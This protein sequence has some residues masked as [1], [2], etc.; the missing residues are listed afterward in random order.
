MGVAIGDCVLDLYQCSLQKLLPEICQAPV[1]N[2]LL[3]ESPSVWAELR[4]SISRLLREGSPVRQDLLVAAGD[5][6]MALPVH[7][8]D[9]TDF[10]SSIHHA[11]RVGK[12]FRPENPLLPNYRYVPI[13]YHG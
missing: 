4:L 2:D 12:L 8:G 3:G 7:V 13:A 6:E 9:Y 1:L 11:T 5:V 10:Y